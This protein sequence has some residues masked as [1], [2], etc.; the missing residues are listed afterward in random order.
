MVKP[1]TY[2]FD[3]GNRVKPSAEGLKTFRSWRGRQGT[4]VGQSREERVWEVKWDGRPKI[5][6]I[7]EDFFTV[8]NNE[9]SQ[10]IE[11]AK[12]SRL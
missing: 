1:M 4:I 7:H 11:R 3:L 9:G 10:V 2:K 6:S 8:L 5:E 12:G